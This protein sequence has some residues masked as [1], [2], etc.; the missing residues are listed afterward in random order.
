[1][2]IQKKH[3]FIGV[4]PFAAGAAAAA[5]NFMF[6]KMQ[7]RLIRRAFG[8][9]DDR[10]DAGLSVPEDIDCVYDLSYGTDSQQKLDVYVPK[11]TEGVLPTIVSI[12][13]GAYVYGDKER[14]SFYCM[15]LARRGFAVVNFSY[16]LAPETRYPGQLHDIN[17]A[18]AYAVNHAAAL[19]LDPSHMFFVGD[20]A[21][22]QLLS[23][24]AAAVTNPDYAVLLGLVIPKIRIPALALNCGMYE[25]NDR[26]SILK[27]Y[28]T[29][30]V[31][32]Y[33]EEL[34]VTGHITGAFPPS[35]VMS[36]WG[37][38]L[39]EKAEPMSRLLSE[40]G[41]ENELHLYGSTDNQPGHVF[42][43]NIRKEEAVLCNDEECAF[44]RK[45]I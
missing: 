21:G 37:D 14:Y 20:S 28:L 33:G 17:M 27:S 22:A 8:R 42:H 18:V 6:Q 26:D 44:F 1:M 12:H 3:V 41:V 31:S 13:G 19:H 40:K 25:L 43:L 29:K 23:Q 4:L 34:D 5:A 39:F 15:D 9:S 38:F 2:K 24:Y 36:A 35:F 7:P 11:G 32:E 45:H 16:R 30:K 10:R